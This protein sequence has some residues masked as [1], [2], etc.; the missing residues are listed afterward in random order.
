MQFALGAVFEVV[1]QI[2]HFEKAC[3]RQHIIA[4][5]AV[6]VINNSAATAKSTARN[7]VRARSESPVDMTVLEPKLRSALTG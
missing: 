4:E 5:C 7:A 3:G 2:A 1:R 6:G